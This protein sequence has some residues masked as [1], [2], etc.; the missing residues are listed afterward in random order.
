[1]TK[2][3]VNG[4]SWFLLCLGVAI[5][6]FLFWG[7]SPN[8]RW[9][10]ILAV[11]NGSMAPTLNVE[12]AIV[13]VK[14][15]DVKIGDVVTFRA[16]GKITTHRLV[17]INSDGTYQ[18]KGDANDEPDQWRVN[19]LGS[20]FL[21][22]IPIPRLG[23]LL[24]GFLPHTG[25]WLE[26]SERTTSK[27]QAGTWVVPTPT[28][29]MTATVVALESRKSS[30]QSLV[31]KPTEEPTATVVASTTS[32]PVATATTTVKP[33][34]TPGSTQTATPVVTATVVPAATVAPTV[35]FTPTPSPTLGTSPTPTQTP[36]R[37][38][39]PSPTAATIATTVP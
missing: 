13:V 15:N 6:I 2:K 1:M 25:A 9:Y 29:T 22:K 7:I 23:F 34:S 10:Q 12:D 30:E 27:I 20:K 16:D 35:I 31:I 5:L 38:P 39:T 8:G 26:D 24:K 18:T 4:A 21:F 32:T 19:N 33:T 17:G 36:T 37:T 14:P 3:I 11:T 28:A